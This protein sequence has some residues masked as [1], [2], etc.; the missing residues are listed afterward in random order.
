MKSVCWIAGSTCTQWET[1]WKTVVR[2]S[3]SKS[4]LFKEVS[5][6]KHNLRSLKRLQQQTGHSRLK[7]LKKPEEK[8]RE[9]ARKFGEQSYSQARGALHVVNHRYLSEL[10]CKAFDFCVCICRIEL[11]SWHPR[12]FIYHNLLTDE[13]CDS[14]IEQARPKVSR[15]LLI[16]ELQN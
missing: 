13:E 4:F 7:I 5:S 9:F 10:Q 6:W 15:I 16:D 12:A 14:I 3:S 1:R 11:I 2:I 8:E